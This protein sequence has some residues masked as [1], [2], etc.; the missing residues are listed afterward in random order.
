MATPDAEGVLLSRLLAQTVVPYSTVP[1]QRLSALAQAAPG[2][3]SG[4]HPVAHLIALD[5]WPYLHHI[6]HEL[7]PQVD[8]SDSRQSR[9]RDAEVA[10]GLN[11]VDVRA[12]DAPKAIPDAH[13]VRVGQR[14]RRYVFLPKRSQ[15]AEISSLALASQH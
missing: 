5:L 2:H 10:I 12:T 8:A 14:R 13:I 1:A 11:E 15:R 9:R 7:V 6:A 3:G 4:R